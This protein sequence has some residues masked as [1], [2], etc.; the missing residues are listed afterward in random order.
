MK[1]EAKIT[2]VNYEEVEIDP[3]LVVLK[4]RSKWMRKN[5]IKGEYINS[6]DFWETWEDTYHGSGIYKTYE[7]ASEEEKMIW[8]LFNFL[9][10]FSKEGE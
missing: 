9:I 2:R 3:E 6:E 5:K 7:K 10:D 1:V 8:G 4:L